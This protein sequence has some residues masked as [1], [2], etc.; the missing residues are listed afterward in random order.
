MRLLGVLT[1]VVGPV[2][3]GLWLGPTPFKLG[4]YRLF[5]AAAVLWF[6]YGGAQLLSTWVAGDWNDRPI[7][8]DRWWWETR[9][10][11]PL[12]CCTALIVLSW[13]LMG[14]FIELWLSL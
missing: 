4:F 9:W 10:G 6:V 8:F 3:V 13:W 2:V 7:N 12:Y 1:V 11:I 14:D 5:V